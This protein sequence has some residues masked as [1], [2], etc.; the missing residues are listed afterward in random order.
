M[1]IREYIA[2]RVKLARYFA[3]VWFFVLMLL[4]FTVF[5]ALLS[6]NGTG[7]MVLGLMPMT[8]VFYLIGR[9]TICPRCQGSLSMMT[10]NA[11]VPWHGGSMPDKCPHCAVSLDEPVKP[12]EPL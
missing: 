2:R 4:A 3:A 9:W 8:V 12:T 10:I 11:F 6:K 7:W 1:T 5:P